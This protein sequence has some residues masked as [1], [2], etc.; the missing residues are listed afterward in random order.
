VTHSAPDSP[1]NT[2]HTSADNF[3]SELSKRCRCKAG[4]RNMAWQCLHLQHLETPRQSSV[5]QV[6][7]CCHQ[8]L[9]HQA[10]HHQSWDAPVD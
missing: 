9:H 6:P 10:T 8:Q 3:T 4:Y 1:E 2:T 5:H 7:R